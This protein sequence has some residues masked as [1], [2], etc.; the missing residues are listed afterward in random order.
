VQAWDPLVLASAVVLLLLVVVAAASIPA[1]R[2]TAVDP[3]R[4][5]RAE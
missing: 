3:N 5:L 2:A 4:S 1:V